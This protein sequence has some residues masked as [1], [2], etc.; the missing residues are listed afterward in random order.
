MRPADRLGS[1][2]SGAPCAGTLRD[3]TPP[4]RTEQAGVRTQQ[5]AIAEDFRRKKG[6]ER[7]MLFLFRPEAKRRELPA[8]PELDRQVARLLGGRLDAS[9]PPYSTDDATAVELAK[10]F[11]KEWGWWHYE[12]R[13]VHGDWSVGWIE[14]SQPLLLSIHPIRLSAP[15]RALAICRSILKVS[16]SIRDQRDRRIRRGE[17]VPELHA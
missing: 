8:G 6:F 7:T 5:T 15:T 14:E 17:P 4:A 1:S 12:K 11:S 13:E 10:R 9:I 2:A 3:S 16:E